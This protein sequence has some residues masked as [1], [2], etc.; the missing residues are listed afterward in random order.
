MT[1]RMIDAGVWNRLDIDCK[2]AFTYLELPVPLGYVPIGVSQ[3]LMV[4]G[5]V[6]RVYAMSV[7]ERTLQ[8]FHD[9]SL[10]EKECGDDQKFAATV[11][12]EAR[13]VGNGNVVGEG[14]VRV[15]DDEEESCAHHDQ[16]ENSPTALLH[17]IQA[18]SLIHI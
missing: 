10:L 13:E 16:A 1:S 12:L 8:K 18:L 5:R 7:L 11:E 2:N 9:K 17:E 14:V 6:P 15:C 4:S 3:M